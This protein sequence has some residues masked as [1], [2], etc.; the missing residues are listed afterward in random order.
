M[1]VLTEL[2]S[3]ETG[4]RMLKSISPVYDKSYVM[5]W[6]MEVM[7]LEMEA[8][9]SYFEELR[10]QAFPETATWG[11]KYWEMKYHLEMEPEGKT[12]DERR[13]LI[14]AKRWRFAP[15]NPARM[16]QYIENITGVP[17]NVTEHP[18]LYTFDISF[19]GIYGEPPNMDVLIAAVK[20]VKPSHLQCNCNL[21]YRT[22]A[23]LTAY[24]HE[25]LAAYTHEELRSGEMT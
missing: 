15:M 8:A 20:R 4:Q 2:P 13:K 5:K 18:E 6:L 22:H 25:Q 1:S 23:E 7:G 14:F 21:L 17:A 24:T 12:L 9:L 19:V 3:T 11:L 10:L 16:E